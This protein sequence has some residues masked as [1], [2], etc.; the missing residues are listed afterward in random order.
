MCLPSGSFLKL[1]WLTGGVGEFRQV[2]TA[3]WLY[4]WLYRRYFRDVSFKLVVRNLPPGGVYTC[5]GY[6]HPEAR[7]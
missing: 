4:R 5:R 3:P 1:A 7:A 2:T 6:I